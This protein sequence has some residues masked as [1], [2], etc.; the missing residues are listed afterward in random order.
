MIYNNLLYFIT[1]IIIFATGSVPDK[2]QIPFAAAF[3][4]FF[5]KGVVYHYLVHNAH[6]GNRV[7]ADKKYFAVD[8]KFSLL[9]I[10]LFAIDV[11]VLDIKYYLSFLSLKGHLP[12]LLSLGGISLFFFYLALLWLAARKNYIRI[13]GRR[14]S[15][16]EFVINNIKLN[17]PIVLPWLIINFIVDFLKILPFPLSRMLTSSEWGETIIVL[18]FFILLAFIFPVLIKYLWN[19]HS[20]PAG[21]ARAHMEEFC[22]QQKFTYSDIMVWPLYEGKMLTAGVMGISKRYRYVLITPALLE[23]LTPFEVEAVLAH[24]IGHVKKYHL[25]LYLVLFLGFGL[26][27]SLI[28]SPLLYLLLNSNIFYQAINFIGI[29]PEAALAF[30]GAAPMF[31]IMLVYFR[32]VFGFFMRNF[33]R[34]A[35]AQVF[36]ALGD[37]TPLINSLE[38]IGWL[39]G[40]IRDKPSWHHFGIS[41]RVDF[42]EK[43]NRDKSLIARHDRKVYA[44]LILFVCL[45]AFSGSIFWN[46]D[47]E[48]DSAANIKFV[49]SILLQRV[50]RE[51][52]NAI[53]H[54]LLGDL[55]QEL[56]QEIEAL[57]AYQKSLDLEPGN[58]EI[59]N[60]LAWLLITAKD[61]QVRDAEKALDLAKNAA[62]LRPTAGHIL[63][64]LAAAY[65][66]NN[67]IDRA[68]E[69]ERAAMK[70]E[71]A[72]RPFYRRQM[73]FFL[74]NTWPA[75]LKAWSKEK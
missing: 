43:C 19:L 9:A 7:T 3:I 52:D 30:W 70:F 13:F 42:L 14:Y 67:M 1:A 73:D 20:M 53:W 72:N 12:A 65:W 34:Q 68:L 54:R 57:T 55:R 5:M 16:R 6:A 71:P 4:I 47:M 58:P 11:Y 46:M 56:N 33:E 8:Q 27:A 18:L 41:Q 29:D 50:R 2:P 63:D 45:L 74:N 21:P 28:T 44:S 35:D 49:E 59:L 26:V 39:S 75:D 69:A 25:Q 22:R 60:N 40:N 31:V 17:L 23:V 48:L 24:E 37:S 10:F 62:S 36:K 15:A 64:T 66:A 38:K 61:P 32:Y 51:P